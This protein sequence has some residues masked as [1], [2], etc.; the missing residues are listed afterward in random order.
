MNENRISFWQ[1]VLFGMLAVVVAFEVNLVLKRVGAQIDLTQ[2][3]RYTIPPALARIA[4][5]IAP[6]DPDA[7]LKI[8]VYLSE[9]LP[10][11]L[12]H[13]ERNIKTRLDEVRRASGG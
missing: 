13:L 2:D 11:Y 6:N 8:T 10:R 7:R 5:N 4:K 12:S 1:W 3:G 9:N